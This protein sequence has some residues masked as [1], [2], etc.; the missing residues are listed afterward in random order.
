LLEIAKEP[1]Y[2]RQH[3]PTR[4]AVPTAFGWSWFLRDEEEAMN[5]GKNAKGLVP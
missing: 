3:A 5:P 1:D 2:D 4:R